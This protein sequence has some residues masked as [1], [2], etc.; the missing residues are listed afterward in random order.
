MNKGLLLILFLFSFSMNVFS[1]ATTGGGCCG[2]TEDYRKILSAEPDSPIKSPSDE[3]VATSCLLCEITNTEKFS[4]YLTVADSNEFNLTEEEKSSYKQV[5]V[6]LKTC[7]SSQNETLKN[8][9]DL[10]TYVRSVSSDV[11]IETLSQGIEQ[12]ELL[13]GLKEFINIQADE[14]EDKDGKECAPKELNKT[15][16]STKTKA[17][18]NSYDKMISS[19]SADELIK[20]K[21]DPKEEKMIKRLKELLTIME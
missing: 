5:V 8:A 6:N 19:C 15:I 17:L 16:A 9:V 4:N 10:L 11:E 21:K 2:L 3:K 12:I 20:F 18:L 1:Q 14:K 7:Q 13:L